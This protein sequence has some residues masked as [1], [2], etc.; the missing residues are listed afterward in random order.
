VEYGLT[1]AY[2]T[3]TAETD[4][5]PRVTSHSVL[6]SSLTCATTYHYRVK[7]KDAPGNTGVSSD[8]TFQTGTCGGTGTAAANKQKRERN[9]GIIE[10]VV[11]T[12]TSPSAPRGTTPVTPSLSPEGEGTPLS[13]GGGGS[14][15]PSCTYPGNCFTVDAEERT[16]TDA[17]TNLTWQKCP[18]GRYGKNCEY[19]GLTRL[20]Q[21]ASEAKC[22]ELGNGWRLPT[23]AE[24][25]TIISFTAANPAIDQTTFPNTPPMGFWSSSAYVGGP[26]TFWQVDFRLGS[27]TPTL[28]SQ[29]LAIRCVK[30]L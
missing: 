21:A 14:K 18:F 12:T 27:A 11:P 7:S 30:S 25:Q 15:T 23:I 22:R 16:V 24:L 5:S 26:S 10:N 1:N 8:G 13:P 6:I 20:P 29:P 17:T 2:G 4:T 28:P 19:G 3:S 9:W